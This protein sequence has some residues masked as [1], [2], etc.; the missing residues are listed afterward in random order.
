MRDREAGG[1][2]SA[3]RGWGDSRVHLSLRL[4]DKMTNFDCNNSATSSTLYRGFASPITSPAHT[5]KHIDN[6]KIINTH[7]YTYIH[8]LMHTQ[9]THAHTHTSPASSIHTQTNKRHTQISIRMIYTHIITHTH[10]HTHT[11]TLTYT[12]NITS[13]DACTN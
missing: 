10:T 12:H 11:H 8:I 13:I 1:E 9:N 5:H 6:H 3:G 4:P 7:K 2:R